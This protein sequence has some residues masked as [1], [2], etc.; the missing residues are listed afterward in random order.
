MT[1]DALLPH[2]SST[3]QSN[4]MDNNMASLIECLL[5]VGLL[6]LSCSLLD[7]YPKSTDINPDIILHLCYHVHMLIEPPYAS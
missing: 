2:L 7:K 3:A 4:E 6:D 1:L 5:S